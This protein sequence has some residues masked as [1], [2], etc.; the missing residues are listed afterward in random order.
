MELNAL[1]DEQCGFRRGRGCMDQVF[2][3]RRVFEKY[4]D[5]R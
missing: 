1:L 5:G 4:A 3:E 2:A